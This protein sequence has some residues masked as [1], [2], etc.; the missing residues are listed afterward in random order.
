MPNLFDAPIPGQSLTDTPNGA[1]WENPPQFSDPADIMEYTM[2]MLSEKTGDIV[3][4]LKAGASVESIARTILYT[5]FTT[6]KWT[7]DAALLAGRVVMMQIV[8]IAARAGL[9]SVKICNPRAEVDQFRSQLVNMAA[10]NTSIRF[11]PPK[12]D[13]KKA[14]APK[15]F[16]QGLLA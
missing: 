3:M 16:S 13:T 7:P 4:F 1:A 14:E 8:A 6:G 10:K 9:E 11:A 15:G 5:G 2:S 12:E